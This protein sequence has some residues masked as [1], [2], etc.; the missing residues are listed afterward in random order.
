MRK[1]VKWIRNIILILVLLVVLLIVLLHTPFAKNLIRGKLEAYL[2]TKTGGK[3]HIASIDYSLLNWIQMNG[4]SVESKTGDTILVGDKMRLDLNLLKVL[5]G[6]YEIN[7]V[8]F[9]KVFFNA[10]KKPGDSTFTYQFLIDAFTTK[11][12]DA[13]KDSTPID[14]SL[15]EIHLIQS[16]GR[17]TDPQ[18]GMELTANIGKLDMYIDSLNINTDHFAL[19]KTDMA[20]VVFNM[21]AYPV[22][23]PALGGLKP[24]LPVITFGQTHIVRTHFVYKDEINGINTDDQISDLLVSDAKLNKSG[25]LQ[26]GSVAV[27]N[28]DVSVDRPPFSNAKVRVDTTTGTLVNDSLG[29]FHIRDIRITNSNFA[30]NDIGR[31]NMHGFDPYHLGV[32]KVNATADHIDYTGPK[33][34]AAISFLSGIDKSGL[35]VDTLRGHFQ[36]SDSLVN[37]SDL[38]LK[39]PRS[40]IDAAVYVYPY[41]LLPGSRADV[42]NRI[43][44]RNNVISKADLAL[45]FPDIVN[46]YR[47]ALSGV[48]TIYITADAD[49]SAHRMV[50][51][52]LNAHTN[53][54][55]ILIDASGIVENATTKNNLRFDAHI[56]QLNINRSV[57]AGLMD[58]RTR[59]QVQLPPALAIRGDV[60]GTMTELN[61]DLTATSAYGLATI[62][63][64]VRNYMSPKKLGYNVRVIARNLETGKWVRQDSIFGK[65]NGTVSLKGSGT[66]YQ[67]AILQA[68]ADLASFRIL[69]HTYTDLHLNLAGQRGNYA[70]KGNTGDPLLR[71]SFDADLALGGKYPAGKGYINIQNANPFAL[72]LYPDS[73]SIATL[74][75][76]DIHSLDPDALNAWLRLDST[77]LTKGGKAYRMDTLVARGYRDSGKTFIT[78]ASSAVDGSLVGNY[79]YTELGDIF[80]NALA[81]YTGGPQ[82]ATLNH[83]TVDLAAELKPD[84]IYAVLLPGLFFDKNILMR[85]RIDDNR[86]DSSRY[87]DISAPGITYNGNTLANLRARA[88]DMNDSLRF[89][90]VADTV[91]AGGILLYTTSVQ[92][93]MRDKRLN[94]SLSSQDADGKE[95]Y[96]LALTGSAEGNLFNLQLKDRLKLNYDDWQVNGNNNIK[97]GAAG[98]NVSQLA[99]SRAGQQ[100]TANSAG[101]ELNAPVDIKVDHF[102]LRNVSSLYNTDSLQIDG[103]LNATVRVGGLDKKVPTLDG[104][105]TVDSLQYQQVPLGRLDLKATATGYDAVTLSGALT[106]YGNN[107]TLSG[108][109]NQQNIN[110][111]LNLSPIRFK[112]LEAFSNGLIKNSSGTLTG[113][114]TI[115]GSPKNPQWNGSI[116]F[117]SVQTRLSQFGTAL[118]VNNQ[119]VTL[120]YP[121]IGFNHF[122]AQDSLGHEIVVEGTLTQTKNQVPEANLSV[123]TENFMV[124]NSTAAT[125]SQLY[126]KAIVDAD[127]VILGP[128]TAP[129]IN[130]S[131]GLKDSSNVT[132]VKLPIVATAKDRE[133]VMQFVDMDTVRNNFITPAVDRTTDYT[134]LNYNLN[135]T[136]NKGAQFNIIID[137]LTRDEL[138]VKGA[139]ELNA[140]VTPGGHVSVTGAYNLTE[141]SYQMNYQFLH[142]KFA[143]QEGSS[144][145]FTGDPMNAQADITA[146]YDI[147]ASPYDLIGNEV[148]DINQIDTKL[149]SQ[150]I[151][152]QV[153]LHITGQI[154]APQIAFDI[155]LKEN[156][157]GINYTFAN[158]IDNK[159]LQLRSDASTIN[160]QVFGL[161]VMGRFIGEQSTDFFGTLSGSGGFNADMLVKESVSRFL[162]DAVNQVASDLIKGVDVTV[163]LA[164]AQDYSTAA[165]RTDLNVA[166]S[167]RFMNDRL[168]VTVGKNF[169]VEGED[170]TMKGQQGT[171][172]QSMPDITTTYKLSK[173]GRYMLKAYQRNQYEAILDGYFVETGVTFSLLMDYNKFS[174]ILHKNRK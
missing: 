136:I 57:I 116:R 36:I 49:G 4:V 123:R 126:G 6:R 153:V 74:A 21:R 169:T 111:Q 174:E 164:T 146:T 167:K 59:R 133:S 101:P 120:N 114:V 76:F 163:D 156:T 118:F 20:D 170:P 33:M 44:L 154:S 13:K 144:L 84:P 147:S 24:T 99:I 107:V 93:G 47:S 92:G 97:I 54:N 155:R 50:F 46:T 35:V 60:K 48:S 89:N 17:Y 40:Y 55:D 80:Q 87:V 70:V 85:G 31:R 51:H 53:R 158:T 173:D 152:F 131:L 103:V 64:T 12:K 137:P 65:I 1:S 58:A 142:R 166:L 2:T 63:G 102:S 96:A 42:H 161:L 121:T 122:I 159:L 110:A 125:N 8:A 168:T 171:G 104:S 15:N 129:D 81:K 113:P 172:P 69:K 68:G 18:T 145:V 43:Q 94:A 14:F 29:V 23:N 88:V 98:F 141:G 26:F 151:P 124:M 73:G 10:V 67:T 108:T 37:V 61:N 38:L 100:L 148:S 52:H 149:Y 162:S 105:L 19:R 157:A 79:R 127:M 32:K 39:T 27:A 112:T 30:Y 90:A 138:Q 22:P 139:G 9:E 66:D 128:V 77:V 56:N 25:S 160:K 91:K 7:K 11:S 117:D 119:T 75:R 134:A 109:Y 45:M 165:Q 78:L 130:G 62:K 5:R 115:T 150:K 16:G 135:I 34:N 41:S 72:G 143:L 71:T 28:S 82:T 83:Y 3:F 106:G 132:F 140:G 95:R 86:T